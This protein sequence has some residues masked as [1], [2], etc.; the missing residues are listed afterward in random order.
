MSNSAS[1]PTAEESETIEE[2]AK[3][4][5]ADPDDYA[6]TQRIKE[7][8][9]AKN[10]V[11]EIR[12]Q[13]ANLI[14]EYG[15]N[16]AD[17]GID[18]YNRTLGRAVASYGTELL[19][20]IEAGVE[21]GILDDEDTE[22]QSMESDIYDFIRYDGRLVDHENEKIEDLPEPVTMG[23]YR[24]FQRLQHKLG[25]SFEIEKQKGPARI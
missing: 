2:G 6:K 13:R 15:N 5:I 14:L 23:V 3:I 7:L 17:D 8:H 11:S 18:V 25:L 10:R 22:L 21:A 24:R 19:P 4:I 16:F 12:N 9:Q 1:E 20:M